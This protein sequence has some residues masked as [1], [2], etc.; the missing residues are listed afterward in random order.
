MMASQF[1]YVPLSSE[2]ADTVHALRDAA[3]ARNLSF[4]VIEERADD[5]MLQN[6]TT[7]VVVF[8]LLNIERFTPSL[9]II[10]VVV[11]VS[12][13]ALMDYYVQLHPDMS[14]V[15]CSIHASIALAD[16]VW[17][18]DTGAR[19]TPSSQLQLA[20]QP[21]PLHVPY[22]PPA[23]ELRLFKD[24]SLDKGT[25][26]DITHETLAHSENYRPDAEGWTDL[27]GRATHAVFGPYLFLPPALWRVDIEFQVDCE[28]GTN[29][30]FFEWGPASAA[31]T[32]FESVVRR[33]G[34]Y[35]VTLQSEFG[36]ADASH[37]L[38]ATNS[39]HLQGRMRVLKVSLQ[40]LSN[41]SA[42]RIDGWA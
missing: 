39:S 24:L 16:I 18:K 37:C 26:Y 1:F 33:S 34:T 2:T 17:L 25:V 42:T 30:L 38:I 12:S 32:N 41:G 7:D 20:G 9:H 40:R 6:A 35:A 10:E 31:R 15:W 36:L 5:A 4:S 3:A 19:L 8:K 27:S 29:R 22:L 14:R 13:E 11:P 23:P 28:D 21:V